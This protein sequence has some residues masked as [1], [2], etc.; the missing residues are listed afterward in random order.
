VVWLLS[1]NEWRHLKGILPGLLLGGLLS[2][3]GLLPVLLL[4][5]GTPPTV[6]SEATRIYVFERLDH[7]LLVQ[8]IKPWFVAR[9][10]DMTVVWLVLCLVTP[11]DAAT[12]R[13]RKFIAGSLVIALVG[14][15]IEVFTRSNDYVAAAWMRFY[16]YRLS[17]MAVPLGLAVAV[18]GGID[19]V[20]RR[21][22]PVWGCL[23]LLAVS[24]VPA[25]SLVEQSYTNWKYRTGDPDHVTLHAKHRDWQEACRWID[26]N[27]PPAERLLTP[28]HQQ[29]FKWYAGRSEV[30]NWKDIPQ[31]A[32]QI[33]DW[34]QRRADIFLFPPN[35]PGRRWRSSII[36]IELPTLVHLAKKYGFRYIVID[37]A[38][39]DAFKGH[40]YIETEFQNGSITVVRLKNIGD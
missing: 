24:L 7:H 10:I 31:N 40:P 39:G 17:D 2:L 15:N 26:E 34:Q 25:A 11:A 20:W 35:R 9:F 23:L 13:L 8:S 33:M 19:Y 36:E 27:L 3:P 1:P 4:N 28:R 37:Q 16:W 30:F 29:T 5:R 22:R 38:M 6:V 12:R 14:V 21:F 18:A 32:A